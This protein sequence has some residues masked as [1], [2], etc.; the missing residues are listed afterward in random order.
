MVPTCAPLAS[1][2]STPILQLQRDVT[3]LLQK[4]HR[5]LTPGHEHASGHDD[6]EHD[7]YNDE[8]NEPCGEPSSFVW[9]R[10]ADGLVPARGARGMGGDAGPPI[11]YHV[12]DTTWTGRAEG[13]CV[14][15]RGWGSA[16]F[17][18]GSV[19]VRT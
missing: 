7:Q 2:V 18:E 11:S 16:N 13:R 6:A 12:I 10:K 19:D 8:N 1:T 14:C 15:V 3:L 17:V 4:G 9:R 5:A